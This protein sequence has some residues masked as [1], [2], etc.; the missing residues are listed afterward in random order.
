MLVGN[1]AFKMTQLRRAALSIIDTPS[2]DTC[3]F[4]TTTLGVYINALAMATHW[5]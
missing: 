4:S 3:Q 1:L 2:A 5:R